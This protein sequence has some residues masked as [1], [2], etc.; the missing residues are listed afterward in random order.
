MAFASG[1]NGAALAVCWGGDIFRMCKNVGG[2]N[3]GENKPNEWKG[4]LYVLE[5]DA[6]FEN[7]TSKQC[8]VC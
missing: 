8:S 4:A 2:D 7:R 3:I 6:V 1:G 5:L